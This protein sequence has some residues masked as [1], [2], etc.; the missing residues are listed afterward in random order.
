M[1]LDL[2]FI[3][4]RNF[5]FD[6]KLHVRC[7][8]T[9]LHKVNRIRYELERAG[10]DGPVSFRGVS[11][12]SQAHTGKP[13]DHGCPATLSAEEEAGSTPSGQGWCCEMNMPGR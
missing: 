11:A 6:G 2:N 8:G 4:Y 12:Y 3:Y 13:S 10:P 9:D 5:R 1:T 7:T